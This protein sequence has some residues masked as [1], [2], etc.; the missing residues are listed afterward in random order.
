MISYRGE[1]T[2][3]RNDTPSL[4]IQL[5]AGSAVCFRI[6]SSS[7]LASYKNEKK[8]EFQTTNIAFGIIYKRHLKTTRSMLVI[9]MQENGE[10]KAQSCTETSTNLHD[11]KCSTSI[12][13]EIVCCQPLPRSS[14]IN[15]HIATFS[16][17]STIQH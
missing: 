14:S 11:E 15:T 3:S 4:E 5:S 1:M 9:F 17:W 12:L 2:W 8:H 16:L 6:V 10:M 7:S 13:E